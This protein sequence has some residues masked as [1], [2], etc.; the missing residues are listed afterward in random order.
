[1][2]Y[3]RTASSNLVYMYACMH[4]H[5]DVHST[6]PSPPPPTPMSDDDQDI[7][8]ESLS[9]H[10]HPCLAAGHFSVF[11][12]FDVVHVCRNGEMNYKLDMDGIV[13]I[14]RYVTLGPMFHFLSLAFSGS[15]RPL[16]YVISGRQGPTM[17]HQFRMRMDSCQSPA[18]LML[19]PPVS[20]D[21]KIGCPHSS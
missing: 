3:T 21:F 12:C 14:S 8:L 17:M 6:P 18:F 16:E 7:D 11:N 2:S 5:Q 9:E 19:S 15:Y 1:M 4:M 20:L 13:G 10:N